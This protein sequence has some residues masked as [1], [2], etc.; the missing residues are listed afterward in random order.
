MIFYLF[1]FANNNHQIK[2]IMFKY[3]RL[4]KGL[5]TRGVIIESARLKSSI[6]HPKILIT[7]LNSTRNYNSTSNN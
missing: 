6:S 5:V 7:G 4:V 2:T 3:Q 1:F